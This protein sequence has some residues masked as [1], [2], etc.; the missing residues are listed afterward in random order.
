MEKLS[1]SKVALVVAAFLGGFHLLW[2]VLVAT[3]YAQAIMDWVYWVHFLNNPFVLDVFDPTRAAMLV[4]FTSVV[5]YVGGWIF[6][7]L[8]NSMLKKNR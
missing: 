6:A 3:G 8:W 2:A 1:Q 7:T 4:V 5:G